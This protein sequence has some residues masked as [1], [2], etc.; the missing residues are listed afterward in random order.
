MGIS[1]ISNRVAR[2]IVWN[3]ANCPN[4]TMRELGQCYGCTRNVVSQILHRAIEENLVSDEMVRLIVKRATINSRV[5]G[6]QSV[7]YQGKTEKSFEKSLEIRERKKQELQKASN[8]NKG[9]GN[10]SDDDEKPEP[11][12]LSMF[13]LF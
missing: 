2:E 7:S 6:C 11:E 8:R 10:S 3:Y 1:D 5:Y 13:S 9:A 12:Q 4:I